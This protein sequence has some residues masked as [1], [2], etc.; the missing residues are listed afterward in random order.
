LERIRL[1]I[2]KSTKGQMRVIETLLA[3]F[4][5]VAAISFVGIFS[6]SPKSPGYEMTDLEKMGYN[7]L[8][9]LDQRRLL[10]PLV[11]GGQATDWSDLRTLLKIT[12][13]VDVYFNLTIH[14]LDGS[15]VAQIVSGDSATFT[16][17]KNIAS[18]TYTLMGISY[19]SD[20]GYVTNF[21]PRV[22]VLQLTRG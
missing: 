4:I 3:S 6:V 17:A 21:D 1:R 19:K 11:Y 8:H 2:R 16:N 22:L 18:V 14:N 7:A 10:A 12:V 5:I 13:P 20:D 15:D 9:D